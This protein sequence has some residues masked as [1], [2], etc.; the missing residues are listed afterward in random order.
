MRQIYNLRLEQIQY[1]NGEYYLRGEVKNFGTVTLEKVTYFNSRSG[2]LYSGKAGYL[3]MS[4]YD[5]EY[6]VNEFIQ[7]QLNEIWV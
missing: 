7:N 1:G 5:N 6:Q 4:Y 3:V 2:L